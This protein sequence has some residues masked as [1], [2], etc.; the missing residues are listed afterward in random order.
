MQPL[1]FMNQPLEKGNLHLK[2]RFVMPPMVTTYASPDGFMTDRQ[3]A[4]YAARVQ[5]GAGL[6]IVEAASVSPEGKGSPNWLCLYDDAFIPALKSLTQSAHPYGIKIIIQLAHA[7]RQTSSEITG[8]RPVAPSSITCAPF[9]ENPLAIS[10]EE[11]KAIERK[12]VEAALRAY[13]A[14]FDGVEIHGAHG[15]LIHQFLSPRTNHRSDEYGRDLTGRV[16]F[17]KEILKG[18]K[19]QLPAD[20]I[21]GC[22]LNGEDYVR[23]GLHIEDTKEI[24]VQLSEDG[25]SYLH[26]SCG[27]AESI[28]MTIPPMDVEPGFLAPLAE[29]VKRR[30]SIPII[31]AGRIND[32]HI[33]DCLVKEGKAD[34]ISMGRALWTDPQLPLK[35]LEGRFDEIRPCIAC[36]QGCRRQIDRCCLMNPETG[37]EK[38]FEIHPVKQSKRLLVIGGGPAGMEFARVSSLRGHE[39]T[40]FEKS[41]QL[42][43]N[44][45]LASIPPKKTEI[46]KG[47]RYLE[48][49]IR[50]L[51][52]RVETEKE[53]TP[54]E[55]EKLKFD[56]LIMA[57]GALPLIPPIQGAESNNVMLAE[58][59]LL[60]KR[61]VG[62]RVLVIGGGMVGCEVADFL[63]ARGKKVILTEILPDIVPHTDAPSARFLRERLRDQKVDI[64]TS[65]EV[66]K[67]SKNEVSIE[68]K[69]E[70]KVIGPID[71]VIIA[72]GYTAQPDLIRA[73]NSAPYR[74]RVI[75]DALEARDALW[76]IY[77][78]A[79]LARDI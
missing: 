24:A 36:N 6:I 13:E 75:G 11:I 47:V 57:I 21:V 49:E 44:F 5:G 66:K 68:Q 45:R 65:S 14:G 70:E 25:I 19:R 63:S 50:R 30:V 42:G 20:F 32:P 34:L 40:I 58:D 16:R 77:E 48:R 38:G 8:H 15:Y 69:G 29:A 2:N 1:R 9:G 73:L 78:G 28:H 52:V 61:S 53:A 79:K 43:G 33:A 18:L 17:L 31:I 62:N 60:E 59:V 26:I 71:S 4:Y 7:G 37:R 54:E 72:T 12:F 35:A 22:R 27:V 64:R 10:V 56:E 41:S 67:I 55:L 76:A 74:I 23:G 3:I 51:G 39:V 46:L